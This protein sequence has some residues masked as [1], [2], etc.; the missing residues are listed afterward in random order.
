MANKLDFPVVISRKTVGVSER[1]FGTILILDNKAEKA[2]EIIDEAKASSLSGAIGKIAQRIYMQKPAPFEVAVF[3]KTGTA[4]EALT[5][6]LDEHGGDFFWLVCTD[7]TT[8]SIKA[9]S[10]L[11]QVNNKIYA[12]TVNTVVNAKA[13]KA[14]ESDNTFIMFHDDVDSYVAEAL[15]VVMSHNVG[16]R[17]A[18]FKKIQGVR[19]ASISA[20]DEADLLKSN[21]FTYRRKLGVLQT[22]EGKCKSGEYIDI[23]L[24]EYWIRFRMEEALQRRALVEDKI[25]YTD[26][27]IAMLVAE[28]EKVLKRAVDQGIVEAKQYKI[29]YV[30]RADAPVNDVSNR[31]YNGIK[32]VALLQGAIHTGVISGVLTYDMVNEEE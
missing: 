17:T 15:T 10:E 11:A 31:V 8:E 21:I 25:P 6:V 30:S 19:E 22:T 4:K 5:A 23:V 13:V 20:T 16:G 32:W 3:G 24:G 27:G 18:K 29:D 7:N 2:W 14:I 12:V 26:R 9:L 1:G 28:C